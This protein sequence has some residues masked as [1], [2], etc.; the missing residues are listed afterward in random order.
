MIEVRN[1]TY[2]YPDGT[3]GLTEAS[4][5]FPPEHIFGVLGQSGSGK[6]TLLNCIARFLAVPRDTIRLDGQDIHDVPE[7][8]FRR[9][10][11]VV[12]QDLNLFPHLTILENMTLAPVKAHG[13][14]P[15]QA[16]QE[17]IEILE[18]LDISDLADTFPRQV[19]GGQAQRAAIARALMLHPEYLLLDEPTSALD[20][21]TSREFACWLKELNADA[22]FVIVTHDVP[23]ALEAASH[24]VYMKEGKIIH[25]GSLRDVLEELEGASN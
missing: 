1:L 21:Q 12:F 6:T 19:S 11:G 7:R 17:A 20:A 2:C 23:F 3:E 13:T 16:R 22:S 14:P 9:R 5:D 18:R 8:E 4:I 25:R 10:I 15:R 24:G